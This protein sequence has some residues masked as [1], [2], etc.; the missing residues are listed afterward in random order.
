MTAQPT[1]GDGPDS[2]E[3][4]HSPDPAAA[5]A[6]DETGSSRVSLRHTRSRDVFLLAA[7]GTIAVLATMPMFVTHLRRLAHAPHREHF[8]L[9]VVGFLALVWWRWRRAP[10]ALQVN[11]GLFDAGLLALS[12][13]VFGAASSLNSPWL[14]TLSLILVAA[15]LLRQ[16]PCA[17]HTSYF[18]PWA[19]LLLLLPFPLGLD[20]SLIEFMQTF[21]TQSSSRLLDL[22][23]VNHLMSGN[24]LELPGKELF[25]DEACSGI[26]SLFAMLTCVALFAAWTHRPAVLTL[27]LL[28]SAVVMCGVVNIVRI[29][30]VVHGEQAGLPLATG[31][32]HE[33]LGVVMFVFALGLVYC[34][35]GFLLF[36]LAPIINPATGTPDNRVA[37]HWNNLT[38]SLHGAVF[39]VLEPD[40][41]GHSE[42]GR[43]IRLPLSV[44]RTAVVTATCCFAFLGVSQ[45]VGGQDRPGDAA[46]APAPAE[47]DMIARSEQLDEG[48]FPESIGEWKR[49]SFKRVQ[50]SKG[51]STDS[52]TWEYRS[53]FYSVTLSLD[54]PFYG[55]H[56]VSS[57]YHLSGWDVRDRVTVDAGFSKARLHR[58]FG[59]SAYL[60]YDAFDAA[61]TVELESASGRLAARVR[62]LGPR[63]GRP[64]WQFQMIVRSDFGLSGSDLKELESAFA[65]L[66]NQIRERVAIGM[67][68]PS[69][70]GVQ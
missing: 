8:A 3:S 18:G 50:R 11:F 61:G 57:C 6:R 62:D 36:L 53:P 14:G 64:V 46:R 66:R 26:Q 54:Y 65:E 67:T 68:E 1:D 58:S 34:S 7:L 51:P 16:L 19:L 42:S 70:G 27:P 40:P 4:P 2:A 41:A 5:P 17:E 30:V 55:T 38:R 43:G 48:T 49:T 60:F 29:V 69:V 39:G 56:N 23:G 22:M 35:E 44:M 20:Q 15:V 13:A 45:H 24:I 31:W 9:V 47:Q 12:V 63:A 32:A 59:E 25:V 28:L 52:V 37:R 21:A 33:A 10:M